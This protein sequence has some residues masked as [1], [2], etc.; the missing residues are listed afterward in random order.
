MYS[1]SFGVLALY[2]DKR[3]TFATS[4]ATVGIGVGMFLVPPMQR[5]LIAETT[6]R[7]A[8]LITGGITLNII[9]LAAIFSRHAIAPSSTSFSQYADI[10]LF[11]K[12]SFFI[13]CLHFF[14]MAAFNIFLISSVRFAT[15]FRGIPMDDAPIM[16][17][18]QG[19]SNIF[20]RLVAV[21]VSSNRW[22]S[23]RNFRFTVFHITTIGGALVSV[24]F[25]YCDS[26]L[27][28]C[29]CTGGAGFCLGCRWAL[30]PGLQIDTLKSER[31]STSWSYGMFIFG[32]GSLLLPPLAGSFSYNVFPNKSPAFSAFFP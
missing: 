28:L 30:L 27:G 21:G 11:R 23:T 5:L 26:L 12:I 7:G 13:L 19:I 3:K 8:A 2:F 22:T 1:P 25:A 18:A 9:P 14:L 17:S 4:A 10:S 32:I 31:F 29:V 24:A 6:W 20:G 15:E 16:L